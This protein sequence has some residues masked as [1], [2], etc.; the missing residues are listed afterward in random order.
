M[1]NGRPCTKPRAEGHELCTRHYRIEDRRERRR[2]VE[3]IIFAAL[4]ALWTDNDPILARQRLDAGRRDG[5]MSQEAYD[6]SLE[7]LEEDLA[8][9]NALHVLPAN[10][11]PRSDLHRLALDGQNIHTKEVSKQTTDALK[12]L[13]D[14]PLESDDVPTLAHIHWQWCDKPYIPSGQKTLRAVMKDMHQWYAVASCRE[15]NDWLYKRAIDG[16]WARIKDSPMKDELLQ[17]LWEEAYESLKMCCDGHISRLCNVLV[18]FDDAFTPQVSVGELLQ[19]KMS[20]IAAKD[21]AV[22]Y[23]VGEA[24]TVFEELQIPRDQRLDWLEA[25]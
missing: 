16:L 18:G 5:V 23:K 19:Q 11:Q 4:D 8:V 9:W 12:F 22:E 13:L 10:V 21:I 25:F 17:R 3:E 7:I 24:W 20:A 15:E 2:R 6:A 1:T 14:T